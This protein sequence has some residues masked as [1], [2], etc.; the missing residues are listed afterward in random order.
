MLNIFFYFKLTLSLLCT[1]CVRA[2]LRNGERR[3]QVG[4][5]RVAALRIDDENGHSPHIRREV[6][7]GHA[8]RNERRDLVRRER[9][10]HEK[11]IAASANVA[12]RFLLY[13]LYK[14]S[15][16]RLNLLLRGRLVH[17]PRLAEV[18]LGAAQRAVLVPALRL[19]LAHARRAKRVRALEH[20]IR[21]VVVANRTNIVVHKI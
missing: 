11:K 4:A 8:Q 16:R 7:A 2:Y 5:E 18:E 6:H 13:A 20:L 10:K 14:I 1:A 21:H 3:E 9:L 15:E 19:P 12:K 17:Y